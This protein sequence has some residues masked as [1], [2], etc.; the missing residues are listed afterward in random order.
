MLL[1]APCSAT[2]KYPVSFDLQG[3]DVCA[4]DLA[5]YARKWLKSIDTA[6]TVCAAQDLYGGVGH[7]AVVTAG[8][9]AGAKLIFASAGLGLV[10]AEEAIPSYNLT[11]APSGP[12]PF[13]VLGIPYQ[14]SKWWKVIHSRHSTTTPL[15]A[16]V[17]KHEGTVILAL[18]A[19][20]LQMLHDD[21]ESIGGRHIDKLRIITTARASVPAQLN[22]Q[23]IEYDERLNGVDGASSGAM[24]SL[25]QRAALHFVGNVLN[26]HRAKTV[27]AQRRR[28]EAALS[29]VKKPLHPPRVK[30]DDEKILRVIK[31]MTLNQKSSVTK[32]LSTLRHDKAIACEQARF[33]GLY[34]RAIHVKK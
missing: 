19:N 12:G 3:G 2:K 27:Q 5:V 26:D 29:A 24:T 30:A 6:R 17:K 25:V 32:A 20:Y 11:V 10:G 8:K 14:P 4:T 21:L 16:M 34:E 13:S 33:H 28:V 22:T 18:P 15:A 7:T 23:K 31:R 9:L 1:I